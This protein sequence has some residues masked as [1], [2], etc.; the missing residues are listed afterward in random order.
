MIQQPANLVRAIVPKTW[1]PIGYLMHLTWSKSQG[2]VQAGPFTGMRYLHDSVGATGSAYIPKVLG[3]YERELNTCVEKAVSLNFQQIINVGAGEGYYAVG[4]A[5]RVPLASIVAFEM[6]PKGQ[7]MIQQ[8]AKQNQVQ[9]RIQI[10]GKCEIDDLNA[11]LTV[12]KKTLLVVDV[13]AYELILLNPEKIPDLK[14]TT[15]LVELHDFIQ[16]GIAEELQTRFTN[17]HHIERIWQDDRHG[18]EFPYN[19][20]YTRCLPHSYLDWA[21]SEWRP[22]KM[23]WYWMEP[24]AL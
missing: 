15:I 8:L 22:E 20:F 21:V 13:E 14:H 19:T 6:E 18:Q 7:Q 24:L 4:M 17:T 23:S 16:R 3:I 5:M 1:R 11:L 9:D 12:G 2:K 10:L